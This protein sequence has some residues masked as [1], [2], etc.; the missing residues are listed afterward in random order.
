MPHRLGP[1]RYVTLDELI[2]F[3]KA[4]SRRAQ[5]KLAI[6]ITGGGARGPYEAGVV[7][8]VMRKLRAANIVPDIVTGT[9]AGSII[10]T[11]LFVDAF[12]PPAG[13]VGGV[14]A[15]RQAPKWKQ[16]GFGAAGAS[17]LLDKA[18]IV[19]YASGE[20]ALPVLGQ[21]QAALDGLEASWRGLSS[22]LRS[23]GS[24]LSSLLGTLEA[25]VA[26]STV[27]GDVASLSSTLS[28]DARSIQTAWASV[29]TAY[30]AVNPAD[31]SPLSKHSFVGE[32]ESLESAIES[33]GAT[34][35]GLLSDLVSGSI[36]LT[37]DEISGFISAAASIGASASRV[38][39]DVLAMLGDGTSLVGNAAK[40]ALWTGV[41]L[42]LVQ[43]V[44]E[45]L[46]WLF[47]AVVG[48]EGALALTNHIFDNA[49]I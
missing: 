35:P 33:F 24:D 6:T 39:N 4:R 13:P 19:Q 9:S 32:V 15:T 42:V 38:L 29:V 46:S 3:I 27:L 37:G 25:G 5:P 18:W 47:V 34:L 14:F 41:V 1:D 48:V 11:A 30:D 44:I 43:L 21:I 28:A 45:H 2:G 7:E 22:D 31:L 26:S 23:A 17:Q 10:S 12:A 36:A 16:V 49:K 8:A 40:L 20:K